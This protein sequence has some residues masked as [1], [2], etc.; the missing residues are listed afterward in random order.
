MISLTRYVV[1][2]YI[3][4]GVILY[5]I[6][7]EVGLMC[8]QGQPGVIIIGASRV[9]APIINQPMQNARV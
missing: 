6:M 9:E 8:L 2:T 5:H 3:C 1:V 7:S 4:D